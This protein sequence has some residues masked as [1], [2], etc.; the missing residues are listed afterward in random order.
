MTARP[1]KILVALSGGVDSAVAAARLVEQGHEVAAAYMKN[2]VNE[3]DLPGECPWERDAADADAVATK[4]GIPFRVV[5]MVQ[6]YKN[7]IVL[8]LLNGYEDGLTPN[9]DV[10]CN[11]EMKFGVFLSYACGAGFEAVATGHYARRRAAGDGGWDLLEGADPNKD[12]SYFLA[13]LQQHQVRAAR[14]PVGDLPKPEVRALARRFDLPV[15]AKKDSQGI[16]FIGKVKMADFLDAYVPEK[17]GSIVDLGGRVLGRHRGLHFF[18]IGQRKGIG[19]ASPYPHEA[20]V[21]VEKRG[22]TNELV[23][24][25]DRPDTPGLHA[26]GAWLGGLSWVHTAV[27][28]PRTIHARPRY[29]AARVEARLIP[30]GKGGAAVWFAEPQRALAPGQICALY[31]GE[32]LLGGGVFQTIYHDASA[33]LTEADCKSAM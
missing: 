22:V 10:L 32:V 23:I 29:R 5:D 1:E 4:L 28:I 33:S 6:E 2:W 24:G 8:Y 9:P 11:R 21:V 17:P 18:T 12:Q 3:D 30:H 19:V 25:L 20:Y 31:D 27:S 16:C 14:F 7:R 26:Q 15:A 13:L